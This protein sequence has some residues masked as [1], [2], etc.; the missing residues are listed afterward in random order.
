MTAVICD[1]TL[2]S[3]RVDTDT[4]CRLID[5]FDYTKPVTEWNPKW[6][7]LVLDIYEYSHNMH[8]VQ[9]IDKHAIVTR[10]MSAY[11]W[12]DMDICITDN[13]L[14]TI[15]I[16]HADEYRDDFTV[17]YNII[18]AAIK[19]H[20][21]NA[22]DMVIARAKTLTVTA[23]LRALIFMMSPEIMNINTPVRVLDHVY[24][25][26]IPRSPENVNMAISMDCPDYCVKYFFNR[27]VIGVIRDKTHFRDFGM[28]ETV[29]INSNM[30]ELIATCG[31]NCRHGLIVWML[32]TLRQVVERK[33]V[34]A[35][36]IKNWKMKKIGSTK[37]AIN[38]IYNCNRDTFV[39]F[40]TT[41]GARIINDALMNAYASPNTFEAIR[42]VYNFKYYTVFALYN[43]ITT[44]PREIN[45]LSD[46]VELHDYVNDFNVLVDRL[47]S[48]TA[49]MDS[50]LR[51]IDFVVARTMD[52]AHISICKHIFKSCSRMPDTVKFKLLRY[53]FKHHREYFDNEWDEIFVYL[54]RIAAE[55]VYRAAF[56]ML[57]LYE[58]T[59][60]MKSDQFTCEI[61]VETLLRVAARN[62]TYVTESEFTFIYDAQMKI[63]AFYHEHY[64]FVVLIGR[65]M[66][67]SISTLE[68]GAEFDGAD[69]LKKITPEIAM[70]VLVSKYYTG[71]VFT[72]LLVDTAIPS[73]GDN[74]PPVDGIINGV[75][76]AVVC[77]NLSDGLTF[78]THKAFAVE[79]ILHNIFMM[80]YST[81]DIA[82]ATR[83]KVVV[84]VNSIRS[85][86]LRMVNSDQQVNE[87]FSIFLKLFEIDSKNYAR[88]IKEVSTRMND[89]DDV[90]MIRI[91]VDR[92]I[93][94]LKTEVKL[95]PAVAADVVGAAVNF[96]KI[97]V[98]FESRLPIVFG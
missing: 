62:P 41:Y 52:R 7:R 48:G 50:V 63:P 37:T 87:Y 74:T 43:I 39:Y 80:K 77:G 12:S 5:S 32:C 69:F 96:H 88:I 14:E 90:F 27:E 85:Y 56:E 54:C 81:D 58:I 86:L 20:N 51:V 57:P 66:C 67:H 46:D 82:A 11:I 49:I 70:G 10:L 68:P 60:Y 59:V 24:S 42:D 95:N 9:Y 44:A 23:C 30:N 76:G 22:I 3:P 61:A 17:V 92:C 75:M 31:R 65:L 15:S 78:D 40:Y 72:S 21:T 16:I 73:T 47:G 36:V 28:S 34:D 19:L 4:V 83:E 2:N 93:Y 55:R 25:K 38:P 79:N 71:P 18:A 26:Y 29:F 53:C 64:P 45:T 1:L 97:S 35:Y 89:M 13:V 8:L 98:I 33:R 94:A 84:V 6:I 91:N